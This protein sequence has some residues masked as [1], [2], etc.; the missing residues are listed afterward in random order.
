MSFLEVS[1]L[2]MLL[3]A[4]AD[5]AIKHSKSPI[6]YA[7]GLVHTKLCQR[8]LDLAIAKCSQKNNRPPCN[9]CGYF[10]TKTPAG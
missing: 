5:F 9:G 4:V 7:Q 2:L 6:R 8:P 3:L 10:L 1:A